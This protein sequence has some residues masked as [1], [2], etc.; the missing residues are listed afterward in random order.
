[1]ADSGSELS[2]GV[3]VGL[4]SEVFSDGKADSKL[5]MKNYLD[6]DKNSGSFSTTPLSPTTLQKI[7]HPKPKR[8]TKPHH[9]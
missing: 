6:V 5:K 2:G 7:Q 4:V 9:K 8:I 3:R 1:M